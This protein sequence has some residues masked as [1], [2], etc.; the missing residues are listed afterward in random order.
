[1]EHSVQQI[2]ITGT[3]PIMFH[4]TE[5]CLDRQEAVILRC[6]DTCAAN[7]PRLLAE[8]ARREETT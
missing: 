1:M 5:Q 6:L 4:Y 3:T 7:P 2:V 8:P